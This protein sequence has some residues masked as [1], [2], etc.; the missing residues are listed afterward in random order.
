MGA[1]ISVRPKGDQWIA[2]VAVPHW[3]EGHTLLLD[4]GQAAEVT[5]VWSAELADAT[6]STATFRLGNT[7]ISGDR[8]RFKA[9]GRPPPDV[10]IP[11]EAP[12]N[13]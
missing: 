9:L 7:A 4:F 12:R 8:F 1:T 3:T 11:C 2:E 13:T 6:P 10:R 5:A